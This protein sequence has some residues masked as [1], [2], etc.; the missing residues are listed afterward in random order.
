MIKTISQAIDDMAV[1]LGAN[2]SAQI[3]TVSQALENV[4]ARL[5]GTRTDL[6][7]MVVSEVI[8]LLTPLIHSGGGGGGDMPFPTFSLSSEQEYSTDASYSDVKAAYTSYGEDGQIPAIF[9]SA[10]EDATYWI[11]ISFTDD[12]SEF[13]VPEGVTEGFLVSDT[14]YRNDGNFYGGGK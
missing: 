3:P 11:M 12:V 7:T 4:Y 2:P 13:E 8:D 1:S 14:L 9:I 6:D 5:G 10:S